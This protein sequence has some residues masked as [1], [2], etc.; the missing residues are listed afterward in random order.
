MTRVGVSVGVGVWEGE[1]DVD[2]QFVLVDL[3]GTLCQLESL[4]GA[5]HLSHDNAGVPGVSSVRTEISG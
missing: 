1:E 3:C 4:V 2:F 5:T